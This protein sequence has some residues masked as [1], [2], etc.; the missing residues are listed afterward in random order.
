MMKFDKL[1]PDYLELFYPKDDIEKK[2]FIYKGQISSV[3]TP[4]AMFQQKDYVENYIFRRI[5]EQFHSLDIWFY[6]YCNPILDPLVITFLKKANDVKYNPVFPSVHPGG[7]RFMGAALR[8]LNRAEKE[9][10]PAFIILPNNFVPKK[11]LNKFPNQF[12][13]ENCNFSI[14]INDP[15]K[16]SRDN[17]NPN[18]E[19]KYLTDYIKKNLKEYRLD[20]ELPSGQIC[21]LNSQGKV[22]KTFKLKNKDFMPVVKE[23][24]EECYNSLKPP[25]D[26]R[27]FEIYPEE[28]HNILKSFSVN[29]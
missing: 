25:V 1:H 15:E 7:T 22:S 16:W 13:F 5:G 2:F 17:L 26:D 11:V 29:S 23:M 3:M 28:Y 18:F 4:S 6:F 8:N 9:W 24:F 27:L 20:L 12:Y 19:F 10:L 14:Q 21:S